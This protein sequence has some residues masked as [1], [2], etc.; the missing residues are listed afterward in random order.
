MLRGRKTG[1][2]TVRGFLRGLHGTCDS[3]RLV[4]W[5]GFPSAD[6][7][8]TSI[9]AHVAAC[10][11][12]EVRR[13]HLFFPGNVAGGCTSRWQN[14]ILPKVAFSSIEDTHQTSKNI[15]GR[16]LHYMCKPHHVFLCT[17][18]G[19]GLKLKVLSLKCVLTNL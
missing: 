9:L 12:V 11:R 7:P 1:L 18:F 2:P 19:Q 14:L 6:T 17:G 5:S 16:R 3:A 4:P 8:V 15:Q 10:K 13:P